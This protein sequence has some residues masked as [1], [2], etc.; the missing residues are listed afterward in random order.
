M[1]L[2][3]RQK[4][5]LIGAIF[6]AGLLLM[7]VC[8]E[9]ILLL[10]LGMAVALSTVALI[11]VWWRCPH[12]GRHLGQSHGPYCPNCGKEIDYDGVEER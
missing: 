2:T 5:Y 4:E 6:A 1:K 8:G 10:L 12:C 9:S 11:H 3:L 7:L